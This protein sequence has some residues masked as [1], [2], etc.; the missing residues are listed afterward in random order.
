VR[1]LLLLAPASNRVYA[2]SAAELAAAELEIC[3]GVTSI[4]PVR[5]AGVEYLGFEHPRP[6]GQ[7]GPSTT[8]LTAV[9]TQSAHLALFEEAGE[10][11]RPVELPEVDL[12]DD[13]FVTIPKYSGKTNEQFTRLLLNVTRA[14][15]DLPS[16]RP[17]TVLDPMCGR[18]TTLAVAWTLGL[19]AAGVELDVK[20]FEAMG[21][22]WR[23]WLRRKRLKHTADITP[24]RRDGKSLGKRFDARLTLPGREPLTASVFTGDTR[25]SAKLFGKRRFELI[26]VD[27]PYGVAH[28]SHS[29]VKGAA[30]GKR[31]RSAAGLLGAAIPVWATQL[32]P[33]GALGI[34]WNTLGLSREDLAAILT[35]AGLEVCSDGPW[36]QFGHRV[37]SS[38][39]R[40]LMVARRIG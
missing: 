7:E 33:G 16:D 2:G 39:H 21:S 28:G 38:I 23:T 40:D 27:A 24:V 29:D 26:V 6:E 37:D 15:A 13:D 9:A 34:S 11:L 35:G 30:V 32:A 17:V 36:L 12:L 19:N 8:L 3:A 25:D 5:R 10:L 31:D 22:F 1:Y 20:A 4:A 18:G 14:A